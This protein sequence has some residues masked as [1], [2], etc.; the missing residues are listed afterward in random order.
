MVISDVAVQ[1]LATLERLARDMIRFS[2]APGTKANKNTHHKRYLEFCEWLELDPFPLTEW[3][4]VLFA[5]YLSLTL[6]T[7]ESIK[8]YCST[9]C[10]WHELEGYP[11]VYRGKLYEKALLGIRRLLQHETKRAQPITTEM[12]TDMVQ[13]IDSQNLKQLATWVTMLYGFFL[14]LRKSN[15]VP[16]TAVHDQLHQLSRGDIKF[17]QDVLIVQIKWSKTNQF[18]ENNLPLPVVRK[19]DSPICPV[20]WLLYMVKKIPA[21]AMHNLF[22]YPNE[23]GQLVPVTYRDLTTLMR[24][25]LIKIGVTDVQRFSS[26]SLRRGGCTHAFNQKIPERIIQTLGMWASDA[27]KRYIDVTLEN[28]LKAWYLMSQ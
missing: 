1:R 4:L 3:R 20:S 15:L 27:Y 14:F 2:N 18:G 26:H 6:S 9:I 28:R 12:L 23:H 17:E 8:N 5:T 21:G 25:L 24:D 11:P 10:E 13:F 19:R 22:S 7:V 16:V